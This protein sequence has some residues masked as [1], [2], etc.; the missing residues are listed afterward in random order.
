MQ[1]RR[2]FTRKD[3]ILIYTCNIY[4][5][6]NIS[7]LELSTTLAGKSP[8]FNLVKNLSDNAN[9]INLFGDLNDLSYNSINCKYVDVPRYNDLSQ[10][11]I[12]YLHINIFHYL[13]ILTILKQLLASF[14]NLP[15]VFGITESN[16]HDK[17]VSITNGDLGG[18]VSVHTPTKSKK[19]CYFEL[20]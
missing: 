5:S 10:N 18:Y 9:L 2:I 3:E 1:K 6:S 7:D 11:S 4:S 12:S 17:D 14:D 20:Y 16:L 8:K 13:I 19:G 15:D